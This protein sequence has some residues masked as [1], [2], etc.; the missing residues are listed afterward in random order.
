MMKASLE[1]L[2]RRLSISER[3]ASI[4]F[5]GLRYILLA[6]C[7]HYDVRIDPYFYLFVELQDQ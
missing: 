7:W 1:R 5:V 2:L 4:R 3:N 6:F